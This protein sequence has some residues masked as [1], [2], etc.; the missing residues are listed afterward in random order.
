MMS[1]AAT[2]SSAAPGIPAVTAEGMLAF[3][4][5]VREAHPEDESLATPMRSRWSREKSAAVLLAA[6]FNGMGQHDA[7]EDG[8]KPK[9]TVYADMVPCLDDIVVDYASSPETDGLT[10]VVF[11]LPEDGAQDRFTLSRVTPTKWE[12]EG[13]I[14]LPKDI[15]DLT[16]VVESEA[17]GDLGCTSFTSDELIRAKSTPR[18]EEAGVED[19]DTVERVL[20]SDDS[21]TGS[22][23]DHARISFTVT[24]VM[25]EKTKYVIEK[26]DTT[27]IRP[28]DVLHEPAVL[29]N[30]GRELKSRF[31]STGNTQCLDQSIDLFQQALDLTPQ[32][33][34]S[35]AN[36]RLIPLNSN[37]SIRINV[38]LQSGHALS[39]RFARR[40][41]TPDV[42]LAIVHLEEALEL[43]TR[44]GHGANSPQRPGFAQIPLLL[45]SAQRYLGVSYV[46]RYDSSGSLSDLQRAVALQRSEC[47]TPGDLPYNGTLF[48]NTE[49]VTL[50][51]AWSRLGTYLMRLFAR[52]GSLPD[53]D[54][55]IQCQRKALEL[56]SS[57]PAFRNA[58]GHNAHRYSDLGAPLLQ[59]FKM[60]GDVT[61][62]DE[63]VLCFR[64]AERLVQQSSRPQPSE[65]LIEIYNG[66]GMSLM[67]RF[68]HLGDANDINDA[69]TA[70]QKALRVIPQDS[71]GL[72]TLINN[73]AL[74]FQRLHTHTH[75]IDPLRESVE[76]LRRAIEVTP[77][78]HP[79]L[80]ATLNNFAS[81]SRDLADATGRVEHIREAIDA[82]NKAIGLVPADHPSL[83]QLHDNLG[84]FYR[85]LFA[86][87]SDVSAIEQTIAAQRK[88]LALSNPTYY[89]Y[90]TI[91]S[92][93]GASLYERY[94]AK[95][96]T[97]D[98]RE[99]IS[100]TERSLE[101][102]PAGHST[103]ADRQSYLAKAYIRLHSITGDAADVERA[104]SLYAL[105]TSSTTT[106]PRRRLTIA[107]AWAVQSAAIQS[108]T[109]TLAATEEMMKLIPLVAG[110]D[111]TLE[112]R[113]EQLAELSML[114]LSAA[115]FA[116]VLA[117]RHDKAVEWLEHGR[118]LV[119]R[120]LSGLRS[121]VDDLRQINPELADRLK[122]LSEGLERVSTVA[123]R[124]THANLALSGMALDS[125][126][127]LHA[128]AAQQVKM[129]TEREKVLHTIRTTIPG[130]ETFLQPS[131]ADDLFEYLPDSGPVIV[132][133]AHPAGCYALAL[134][135]AAG[136]SPGS[137]TVSVWRAF[138]RL[139]LDLHDT[140]DSDLAGPNT[141]DES[142]ARGVRQYSRRRHSGHHG[143]AL[144][145]R[146]LWLGVVKPIIEAL[147]LSPLSATDDPTRIWWCPTGPLTSLPIHAAGIYK[148]ND[149]VCLADYAVSSYTPTVSMLSER[150]KRA[151]SATSQKDPGSV[152]PGLFLVSQPDTPGYSSI[153]GTTVEAKCVDQELGFSNVPVRWLDG[154][155]A[156]VEAGLQGMKEYNCIHFACHA[157]QHQDRPLES[158]FYLHDGRLDLSTIMKS[159][160]GTADLA[161]LSACQTS[162][163]SSVVPE[164]AVH[165]AAGMLS[166][167][168]GGVVA[169]MWSIQD[170]YAPQIAED[171]YRH[172]LKYS[173]GDSNA[174]PRVRLDGAH[175]SRA[176]HAA[177]QRLREQLGD[178]D[179]SFL[180]WVPYVHFG[181]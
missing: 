37:R 131:S 62:I 136:I 52:T 64:E 80:P 103:I 172:L 76:A 60:K 104:L 106:P 72:H 28:S 142:T 26:R 19:E 120:Q 58:P 71:P 110:M 21:E 146:E 84:H 90:P 109:Q 127:S 178:S 20:L 34:P 116:V 82:Q 102:T 40:G 63:A 132:L 130:F 112:K 151:R 75:D 22:G 30:K 8:E 55:A 171:F 174:G 39:E 126:I 163:G 17:L 96:N 91:L 45:A 24:S 180:V 70:Q 15:P 113:Y 56:Q 152:T 125:K 87:T 2:S 12:Y 42:E 111:Q 54:E 86:S 122:S 9:G 81:A 49:L 43:C 74:C 108:R 119:W 148:G 23:G 4:R 27:S 98:L 89:E 53:I 13:L 164:E 6:M 167:G 18:S 181:L 168:Y 99:S 147:A 157:T 79:M 159:N 173:D 88:A 44:G 35:D 128:E 107:R 150:V 94:E 51:F 141:E 149:Q 33:D 66:L 129:A 155:K 177:T 50:A 57:Y 1:S 7:E 124:R 48:E 41:T 16:I 78:G 68:E 145:L 69:I 121:P 139:P 154:D 161:F 61:D 95:P 92:S 170:D 175:A 153:P 93:L 115:L 114:I 10:L 133:G 3:S 32:V 29:M 101:L 135:S 134:L 59:R 117:E 65:R 105:A 140:S 169:T 73:L 36:R 5:A 138:T 144:V 123:S 31:D 14:H 143:V 67:R 83:S 156:T 38:L 77:P 137:Y 165:L 176:L 47:A 46:R 158:G 162:T 166:A 97:A 85:G 118:G 100:L 160:L 179:L 11:G 25:T